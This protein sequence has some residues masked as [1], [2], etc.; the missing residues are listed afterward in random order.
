MLTVVFSYVSY[1]A[2]SN[3]RR[4]LVV[5]SSDLCAMSAIG[6]TETENVEELNKGV[7]N[8]A[9]SPD[10]IELAV[11]PMGNQHEDAAANRVAVVPDGVVETGNK[12]LDA[13]FDE[14]NQEP[15]TTVGMV[16]HGNTTGN[17][18]A[19]ALDDKI[20]IVE[21]EPSQTC[22]TNKANQNIDSVMVFDETK[23]NLVSY[24][25][26]LHDLRVEYGA[27]VQG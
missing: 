23:A 1:G 20:E 27:E 9:Y 15:A 18:M 25:P 8:P 5:N 24:N 16:Q 26:N 17:M 6:L 3:F 11:K 13:E 10:E 4:D 22:G 7:D 19:D 12:S 21:I 14:V 2:Y